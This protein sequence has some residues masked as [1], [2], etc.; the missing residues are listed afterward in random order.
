MEVLSVDLGDVTTSRSDPTIK[1]VS[2]SQI[3]AIL[4]YPVK[5]CGGISLQESEYDCFGFNWDRRWMVVFLRDGHEPPE[6]DKPDGRE[7]A[8][9]KMLS[10]RLN[11]KMAL[12]KPQLTSNKLIVSA[13]GKKPLEIPLESEEKGDRLNVDLWA[14]Q[15]I[16][17]DEGDDIAEWYSEFLGQPCRLVRMPSDHIRPVSKKYEIEGLKNTASFAD[18]FPFL[19]ITNAS[20]ED[21]NSRLPA[22]LPMA[23]F[24]PN[25]VVSLSREDYKPFTEDTWRKFS[26]GRDIFYGAKPCSRCKLTTVDP[27]KG[28]FSGEEPLAT[29]RKYRKRKN[30]AVYFGQNLLQEAERGTLR[31]GD[32]VKVLKT[33]E[34]DDW[35]L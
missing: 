25:I 13:P 1:E 18:G 19:L 22:P 33:Q 14:T 30:G 7:K 21:L 10:Q 28:E 26:L 4:I 16:G 24:R 27:S 17:I 34:R 29:L 2:E 11:P 8:E 3:T 6:S 32:K 5:S 12:L 31:V 20:L 9:Y 23:R 15:L 35:V